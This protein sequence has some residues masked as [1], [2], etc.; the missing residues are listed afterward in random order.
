[1]KETSGTT[2]VVTLF[3][4]E[5]CSCPGVGECYHLLAV[6]MS[7][8]RNNNYC[9]AVIYSQALL[10]FVRDEVSD[11]EANFGQVER[12]LMSTG[13][14]DEDPKLCCNGWCMYLCVCTLRIYSALLEIKLENDCTEHGRDINEQEKNSQ[15]KNSALDS[16]SMSRILTSEGS[17]NQF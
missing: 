13:P 6:R 3:P 16:T 5:T 15:T 11:S 4:K 10:C 12:Y 14:N 8:G 17:S 2:R 9:I 1:M 7:K